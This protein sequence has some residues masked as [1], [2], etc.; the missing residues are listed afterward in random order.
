MK[1]SGTE[2]TDFIPWRLSCGFAMWASCLAALCGMLMTQVILC[3]L[4]SLFA[5]R[6][7][8]LVYA[9]V[10]AGV[11]LRGWFFFLIFYVFFGF[12]FLFLFFWWAMLWCDNPYAY[13]ILYF[14][15]FCWFLFYCYTFF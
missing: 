10:A 13:V 2:C 11:F 3:A 1:T 4:Y 8:T 6:Q 12:L 14:F 15:V 9:G 5:R 7:A